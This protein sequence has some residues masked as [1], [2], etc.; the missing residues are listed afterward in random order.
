MTDP[1]TSSPSPGEGGEEKAANVLNAAMT[2]ML[3]IA[4]AAF[5]SWG[6]FDFLTSVSSA[7]P[8][9]SWK[10]DGVVRFLIPLGLLPT[11]VSVFRWGLQMSKR[12]SDR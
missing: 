5:A 10:E 4:L 6:I 8:S 12:R 1:E 2:M 7:N 3:A 11:A 9:V